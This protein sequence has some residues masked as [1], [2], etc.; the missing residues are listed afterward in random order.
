[1]LM[2]MADKQVVQAAFTTMIAQVLGQGLLV[3]VEYFLDSQVTLR[4]LVG[5]ELPTVMAA[6]AVKLVV[7]AAVKETVFGA[8]AEAAGEQ[9]V[10]TTLA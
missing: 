3:V 8:A 9:L 1:M 5:H 10:V 2:Y 6:A 7:M 4:L